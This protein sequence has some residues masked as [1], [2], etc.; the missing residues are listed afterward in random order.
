MRN[1]LVA[2]VLLE[3]VAHA[4]A[5]QD[6][7]T[8]V[9]IGSAYVTPI[10][11]LDF[12]GFWR[13]KDVGSGIGTNFAAI[14]Y[15]GAATNQLSEARLSMQNSR[16]GFRV[17]SIVE[18]SHVI[19]Y[20]EADFL[21][22]NPGNVAVSSNSNTLRSRLYWVDLRSDAWELL[23]GQS[24]SLITPGR[25]GISPLPADIFFTQVIDV[26]YH[27]GLAWG[28]IPELRVAFHPTDEIAAAV[29]LDNPE[30][31]IG[32][33]AGGPKVTLPMGLAS[34]AGTQL[35]DGTTTLSA[36]NLV[37]DIIGK[38]ALDP[39]K[40]AHVEVAGIFR[41]FS[42]WDPA[43]NL[44]HGAVGAG[45]VFSGNVE[46]LPGLRA[47]WTGM[48]GSG[49]GRYLFGQVPD[50]I[51]LADGELQT[52][53]TWSGLAGAEYTISSTLLFAYA[54]GIRAERTDAPAVDPPDAAA[55][56]CVDAM[57]CVGYGYPGAPASHNKDIVELTVGANHTFWKDPKYGALNLMGQYSYVQR[58]PWAVGIGEPEHAHVNMIFINLRWSLPG[59]AP[60]L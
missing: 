35:N 55:G 12:T 22:N 17:D 14:P 40:R 36:P 41:K 2:L 3:G 11:F 49:V 26:N 57:S 20:M 28:R 47:T 7:P 19:G 51:V 18:G 27:V 9:K 50:V 46:V 10:G 8:S 33:S 29:A 4:Q 24:W 52:I 53:T 42:I 59:A 1:L 58:D 23:G 54:G 21:G 56:P 43:T 25:S 48:Y 37:P 39:S 30:Q 44:H 5:D 60:K 34:L 16:I 13:S 31:Y 32:G 38:V 15:A 45:V 6:A